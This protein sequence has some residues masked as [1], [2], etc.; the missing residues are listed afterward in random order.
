VEIKKICK[1]MSA[2]RV[3]PGEQRRKRKRK[4]KGSTMASL[5]A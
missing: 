3:L 2:G 1:R 4:E 5:Q